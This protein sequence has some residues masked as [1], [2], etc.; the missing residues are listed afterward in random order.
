MWSTERAARFGD[1]GRRRFGTNGADKGPVE[2]TTP[3]NPPQRSATPD[4]R[5]TRSINVAIP[6]PSPMHMVDSPIVLS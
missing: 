4:R 1:L 5:Y 2:E 6:I 3:T